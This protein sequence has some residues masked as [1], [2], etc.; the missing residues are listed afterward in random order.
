MKPFDTS[1][2]GWRPLLF[3]PVSQSDCNNTFSWPINPPHSSKGE[4][5]WWAEERPYHASFSQRMITFLVQKIYLILK[6]M[7]QL[8]LNLIQ[9]LVNPFPALQVPP[10][11]FKVP[12]LAFKSAVSTWYN[13]PGGHFKGGFHP[14]GFHI[15]L[16]NTSSSS[17]SY[18]F[19]IQGYNNDDSLSSNMKCQLLAF[20]V[21]CP[22]TI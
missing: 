4:S 6:L 1:S 5:F 14:A 7:I 16:V 8:F 12:F 11:S 2:H 10:V 3:W 9:L 22:H 20:R 21:G 18:I 19:C 13:E 17:C 15:P